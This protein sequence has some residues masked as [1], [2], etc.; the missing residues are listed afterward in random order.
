MMATIADALLQDGLQIDRMEAR[1][2]GLDWVAHT[3]IEDMD[4]WLMGKDA[5]TPMPY[6]VLIGCGV[7]EDVPQHKGR[8]ALAIL[9]LTLAAC[10]VGV[11]LF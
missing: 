5:S 8:H 9:F 3:P 11:V 1:K 10:I 4:A 2:K 7:L 6:S